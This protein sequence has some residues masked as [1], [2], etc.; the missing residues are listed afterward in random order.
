MYLKKKGQY[1]MCNKYQDALDRLA[2]IDL[3][4][5]SDLL[6]LNKS[7]LI[8]D[9]AINEYPNLEKQGAPNS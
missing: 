5:V 9:Y 8:S 7:T 1:F 3:D 2:N 4:V 6:P